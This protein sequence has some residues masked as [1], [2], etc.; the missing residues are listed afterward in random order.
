MQH[1]FLPPQLFR[2][3]LKKYLLQRLQPGKLQSAYQ[4]KQMLLS[5]VEKHNENNDL[6]TKKELV[7][8]ICISICY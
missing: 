7:E 6:S 2:N 1:F 3:M 5:H 8:L 4:Y